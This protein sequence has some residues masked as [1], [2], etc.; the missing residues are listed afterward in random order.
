MNVLVLNLQNKDIIIK[1]K[2]KNVNLEQQ[3]I[4]RTAYPKSNT[5]LI[6]WPGRTTEAAQTYDEEKMTK[7]SVI[8]IKN[9]GKKG[10]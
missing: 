9:D 10:V 4:S 1:F 2:T 3:N 7:K 5:C 8:V 6:I